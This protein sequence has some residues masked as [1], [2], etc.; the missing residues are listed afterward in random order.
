MS[1]R[2]ADAKTMGS[3][4]Q[5]ALEQLR[6]SETYDREAVRDEISEQIHQAMQSEGVKPSELA[7]RLGKSRAYVTKILQG[8]ANFTID[9]L[10]Q[11][12]RALGYRYAPV[13]VPKF[14]S[15]EAV[16]QTAREIHL[17][18]RAAR[19]TPEVTADE[20]D[21]I[22]VEVNVEGGDNEESGERTLA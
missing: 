21:Y 7:R 1:T 11:I 3:N 15:D 2:K 16:Y 8:N 4:L 9:S 20:D 22:P 14:T 6:N 17:S 18:A 12:A 19:P 5:T 13:F 10:V